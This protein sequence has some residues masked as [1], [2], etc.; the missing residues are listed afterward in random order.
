MVS[1]FLFFWILNHYFENSYCYFANNLTVVLFR[2]LHP[3]SP[4]KER[5]DDEEDDSL[6]AKEKEGEEEQEETEGELAIE[7]GTE[8]DEKAT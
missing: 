2:F 6:F 4:H 5:E 3:F 8:G 7:T 1:N